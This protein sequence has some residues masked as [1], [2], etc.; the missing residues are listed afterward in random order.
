MKYFYSLFFLLVI[1][2]ESQATYSLARR[3]NEVMISA[4]RQDLARPPV[5]ARN[6]FHFSIC[7]YDAWSVYQNNTF[8]YVL[9]KT[10]NGIYHPYNNQK[11]L[12]MGDTNAS[13]EMALSY[14]AYR[15]LIHRFANSPNA[16]ISKYRF[17]T[18]MI[19]L[20]YDTSYIGTDYIN[21]TPA[22]MGNYIAQR[23]IIM[24]LNDG[25]NQAGNY[26]FQGY[27]PAN[28][29]LHTDSSDNITMIDPNRW[30][31]LTFTSAL[32]QGGNPIP[33]TPPFICPGWGYV[34]PFGLNINDV[35]QYMRNGFV[36]PVYKDPGSI[37]M[38]NTTDP[39]DSMS[40]FFKLGHTMVS[41]WSS[42][43]DPADTTTL[44]ISPNGQGNFELNYNGSYGNM[45]QY[46]RFFE[47]GDTTSGYSINPYTL[48]PYTPNIVKRGD[49]SRVVSQYWADGPH[50]ETP[51]GHWFVLFNKI[52]EH[53]DLE[54]RIFGVGDIVSDL[55]WDVK[56]YFT[57]GGTVH[58]AAIVAWSMKGWYDSPRPISAIRKMALYGQSSDSTLPSYHPAGIPLIP[59]YVE[60]IQAGDSLA[61]PN[62][63][64]ENK[65]KLYT[66]RGFKYINDSINDVAGVGWIRAANWM[67]YQRRYFVT[68][69]FAG[70]VS[71]HSTYS[72]SSARTLSLFT[73]SEYFPGGI[74]EYTITPQE[75]FLVLE[76]GPSDTIH[77]QWA[78][79]FD[80]S[81]QA[82]LSRIW[83]GI[84]PYFDDMP[85]R[86]AGDQIGYE[87]I[88]KA[89]YLF[90]GFITPLQL[91]YFAAIQND[92]NIK[93]EWKTQNEKDVQAFK[94]VHSNNGKNF[95]RIIGIIQV[96][97]DEKNNHQYQF[98]DSAPTESGFYRLIEIDLNNKETVLQTKHIQI[99][100]CV[101]NDQ[102]ILVSAYPNPFKEDIYIQ[103]Q[104]NMQLTSSQYILMDILGN[105][106]QKGKIDCSN[107]TSNHTIHTSYL[108]AGEYIL[109]LEA[110]NGN[111]FTH[112][113]IKY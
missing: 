61:G 26:F 99:N 83:G 58:D 12:W 34:N 91:D 110:D 57:L 107:Y 81:N 86:I 64:Y 21:G 72:R 4:I 85:G 87:A 40:T 30:Q 76:N 90:N 105:I 69:P 104:Q 18:L 33:S 53:P 37:P 84:H 29:P 113:I 11:P 47:G 6:L 28:P 36:F 5:Q 96:A 19:N 65:I 100:P 80:A 109:K 78:K 77:L 41:I 98:T 95:D 52:S 102:F 13:I 50:S 56:G 24:G 74:C 22:D 63:E 27:A 108:H 20:G 10:H 23:V 97:H 94:I 59:G 14:A 8:E 46:Y 71:G 42:H 9:G 106:V 73:G 17:D 112:K 1:Q 89:N 82:S 111:V 51:P 31:P 103:I 75:H 45:L 39:N 93:L 2:K 92:C 16:A 25:S 88:S 35:T 7:L 48:Q 32:D 15:F 43:L 44:D 68:P 54:K 55:E 38:L 70:F 3:W 60:L 66:W 101:N 79:Y 62:N 67:P 49:Y